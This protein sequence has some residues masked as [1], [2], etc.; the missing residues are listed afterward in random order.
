[1]TNKSVHHLLFETKLNW[2]SADRGI[3]YARGVNG[4]VYVHT[5]S[6]FGGSGKEWS[7]EHLFL[8]SL[9][10]CYMSTFLSFTKKY[11]FTITHFECS[12][13]GE[14]EPEKGKYKFTRVN[15]YPKIYIADES[16]REK[17]TAVIQKT[18]QYCLVSNSINAAIIYHSQVLTEYHSLHA[19]TK[20]TEEKSLTR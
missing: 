8:S 11:N 1:M 19:D 12:A 13:I 15:I 20:S 7:P 10:S 6:E 17:A 4:P 9:I 18:Q 2:L 3:L 5:A 14:I 16:L